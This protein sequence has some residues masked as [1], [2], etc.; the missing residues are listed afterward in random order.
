MKSPWVHPQSWESVHPL[1]SASI[2]FHGETPPQK[3]HE[4]RQKRKNTDSFHEKANRHRSD[5]LKAHPGMPTG[6]WICSWVDAT[7]WRV[8]LGERNQVGKEKRLRWV[9]LIS[10]SSQGSNK[11]AI[12]L[13]P[14][15]EG[16]KNGLRISSLLVFARSQGGLQPSSNT[17]WKMFSLS[18]KQVRIL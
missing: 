1:I 5:I 7:T 2:T 16:G 12:W 10:K 3:Q 17:S 13:K 9:Q 15:W 14:R 11:P 4:A 8:L 6:A 18:K